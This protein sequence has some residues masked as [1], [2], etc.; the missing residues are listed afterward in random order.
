[1][2]FPTT[3]LGLMVELALGADLSTT[4]VTSWTWTDITRYVR[5]ADGITITRGRSDEFSTAAP[6]KAA[7]TLLN[8]GRFVIRNPTGAYYGLIARNTPLRILVRPDVNTATDAFGRTTSNGWGTADTGGAWTVVGTAGDYSTTSG[9]ARITH[10]SAAV[11]HYAL[12]PVSQQTFDV[13]VRVRTGA[14]ATGAALSAGVV[15]RYV[16]SSNST[17]F[18][19][20]FNTDQTMSVRAALR[21]GGV[22]SFG[23]VHATGLTH[24]ANTYYRVRCRTISADGHRAQ[25]KVWADAA[26]EPDAWTALSTISA[27]N[28]AGNTGLTSSRETGNTTANA[29]VDFDDFSL[30]DGWYPRHTGFVDEWPTRWNDAGLKQAI[31]PITASGMLRRLQQGTAVG[32]AIKRGV[33]TA[34]ITPRAYWPCEVGSSATQIASGIPNGLPMQITQPMS[35]GSGRAAG[36]D[37]IIVASN[38]GRIL[39]NVQPY[40]GTDWSVQWLLSIPAA[41]GA[42]QDVLAWNTTGSYVAWQLVLTPGTPDTLTLQ[43]YDASGV[44]H[45]ADAGV[46][47][48]NIY[49]QQLY[50]AVNATQVGADIL[51]QYFVYQP[52]GIATGK[53]A[54][55]TGATAGTVSRVGFGNGSGASLLQGAT[56]GHISVWDSATIY[57]NIGF[58]AA[59]GWSG[60]FSYARLTR[61]GGQESVPLANSSIPD[62]D[63][64]VMG[65]PSSGTLLS[66]IR[67]IETAEQGLVYDDVDARVVLL[68]REDRFNQAV[69]LTLDVSQKQV[70]WPLE[71]ADDDQQLHNDVT[72]SSPSGSSYR[73][74]DTTSANAVGKVGYYSATRSVNL[75]NDADLRQDA[76][77]AAALGTVDEIRYPQIPLNLTRSPELILAWLNTNIGT[78]MQITHP[79]SLLTPDVIDRIVEGYTERLDTETWTAALNTSSARPWNSWIIEN[80]SGN[81]S[82]LDSEAST[83][84]GPVASGAT[85]LPV[86]TTSGF[87]LWVTGAAS[88]DIG[89]S[90]ERLTVTNIASLLSDTFTRTTANGWG[91]ADTGQT[92]TTSGGSASDYSTNGTQGVHN[93]STTVTQRLSSLAVGLGPIDVYADWIHIPTA[94]TGAGA[95]TLS[96]IA[97]KPDANNY[98]ELQMFATVGGTMTVAVAQVAAGSVV[99]QDSSFPSVGT[100][101]ATYSARL[102]ITNTLIQGRVWVRGTTEP[103]TWTTSVATA[104]T[105]GAGDLAWRTERAAGVTNVAPYFIELDGL[106]LPT[107][108][109]FTVSRSVNA[110]VKA[111]SVG[112]KVSLWQPSV[113]AL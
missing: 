48:P 66:Q 51:W 16:D 95:V 18:D 9:V 96:L 8:D 101:T 1:M 12:L 76:E 7:L 24:V 45:L 36:S 25:I 82:R 20:L 86:S 71:P 67:E 4:D 93:L 27:G 34:G 44:E 85:T 88:F 87:P 79:P 17:R 32:S 77:F 10:P 15:F 98:V 29:V 56:V 83:L 80:G 99:A 78:R 84:A 113:L 64:A 41:V 39:G 55:R 2:A 54:T 37:P 108:Q 105:P 11:R 65:P 81:T 60:E 90:G 52:S 22:D 35:L 13:R 102:H 33:L 72:S 46:S 109:A 97:C 43:A 38:T 50:F 94:P 70:S 110:V 106:S 103:T 74:L 91:T 5:F 47:L 73:Y 31:A 28:A 61:L 107:G 63:Y 69:T 100:L 23:A 58:A 89:V 75:A 21:V 3:K 57:A 68:G 92:W 42:S 111:Q 112:S 40:T 62:S 6:S 59:A 30:T 104:A 14:L 19:L 53:T 26:A 49:A